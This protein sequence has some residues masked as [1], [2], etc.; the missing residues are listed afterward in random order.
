MLVF[1]KNF[2]KSYDRLSFIVISGNEIVHH[3][4]I[5]I[6]VAVSTPTGLLVPVLR[7]CETMGFA[8]FE[9]VK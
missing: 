1:I 6:S 4:Y 9:K 3:D 5:D 8:D 7:N 2:I